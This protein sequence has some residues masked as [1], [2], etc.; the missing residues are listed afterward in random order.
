MSGHWSKSLC[1]KGVSLSAQISGEKG[2]P[3]RRLKSRKLQVKLS[4]EVVT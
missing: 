3:S 4:R 1:S 2:R